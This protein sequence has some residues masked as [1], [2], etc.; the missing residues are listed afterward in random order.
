MRIKMRKYLALATIL[1]LLFLSTT[2]CI[3]IYLARDLL[4]PREKEVVEYEWQDHIFD[5]NFTSSLNEPLELYSEEFEV[6]VKPRTDLMRFDISIEMRSGKEVWEIINDT[7][8]GPIKEVVL[9]WLEQILEYTDQRYIE[10]TISLPD[11]FELYKNTFNQ[12]TTVEIG[13]ITSPGEGNWIIEIDAA[14]VGYVSGDLEYHDAF[15]IKVV[16]REIK[17]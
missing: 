6:P 3:D 14:G 12:T 7:F 16:L 17:E 5:H 13:P 8:P 15:S 4:V 1:V 10:I 2:G 11:G 9:E